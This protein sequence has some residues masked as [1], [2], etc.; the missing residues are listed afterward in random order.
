[1]AKRMNAIEKVAKLVSE[2]LDDLDSS[3]K[4]LSAV[5][6]KAIRIAR[7][8]ND[9]ENLWWLEYEM[10][11]MDD[12]GAR[13][14]A[15]QEIKSHLTKK[16]YDILKERYAHA[17]Q[18]ERKLGMSLDQRGQIKSKTTLCIFPVEEI[19]DRV[20][21]MEKE[22]ERTS[23]HL[24]YSLGA[25][26]QDRLAVITRIRQRVHAF[27]SETERQLAF[28]QLNSD[29]FEQ[30]RLYVDSRLQKIAPDILEK[31]ASAYKRLGEG[32][33]EARSQALTSCRRILK[34]L[35]DH[36]Y[37]ATHQPVKCADGK[38]R[39]LTDDKFINRLLQFIAE[40]VKGRTS[41]DLLLA[42]LE[43]LG[44]RLEKVHD[45]SCK[46]VHAEISS[47]ETNQCV[48][49]TYLLLGDILRLA[50]EGSGLYSDHTKESHD[51]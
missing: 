51:E 1:M 13:M 9:F 4:K 42:D 35:A 15:G 19:E 7:L 2:A 12:D 39:K 43:D 6:R 8:R 32:D 22:A 33:S 50:E 14:R 41:G 18:N 17:Y 29:I 48:I 30:N 36:L 3:D 24:R 21:L 25:I 47:L 45:L 34:S 38:E 20:A 28:G 26:I 10:C 37:P 5:I 40:K 23:N 46:G 44:G 27:L 16:D 11:S 31:F 49:K